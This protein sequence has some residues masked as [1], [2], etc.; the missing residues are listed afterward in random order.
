VGD[1]YGNAVAESVFGLFKSES[2]TTGFRTG[3]LRTLTEVEILTTDY[4]DWYNNYRLHSLL[5]NATP[6]EF[7]ARLLCTPIRLTDRCG[8]QREDVQPG[9]ISQNGAATPYA[10]LVGASLSS[11]NCS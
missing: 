7:R 8:R 10:T 1:A 11:A 9:R 3:F 6:E 2:V 5:G 4:V